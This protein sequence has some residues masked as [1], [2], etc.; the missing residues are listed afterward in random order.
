MPGQTWAGVASS[1]LGM[2]TVMMVAMM[3]P[4]VAP[5]LWSYRR[6]VGRA[7]AWR[8][9]I[10]TALVGIAYVFV[11][12]VAGVAVLAVGIALASGALDRPAL[13][14]AAPI[15]ASVVVL[16]AGA[17]QLTRWKTRRLACCRHRLGHRRGL[18]TDLRTAWRHGVRL[19]LHCGYCC[20]NLM[21]ILLVVDVMDLR[22]MAIVGVAITLERLA[23]A[24]DRVARATGA[25]VIG[26]GL[27]LLVQAAG[28]G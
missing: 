26:G 21:A 9:A 1:F 16:I 2:W 6:A 7:G 18:P 12:T 4:S 28:L 20:A 14:R 24:G 17:W 11:W 8:S 23:P 10:L 19:G 3:L 22:A 15:A 5:A 27:L 25:I 13:A